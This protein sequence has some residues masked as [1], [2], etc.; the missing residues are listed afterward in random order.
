MEKANTLTA[1]KGITFATALLL[2]LAIFTSLFVETLGKAED[3]DPNKYTVTFDAN[4]GYFDEVDDKGNNKTTIARTGYK[5]QGLD[6]KSALVPHYPADDYGVEGKFFEGWTA[7]NDTKINVDEATYDPEKDITVKAVWSDKISVSFDDQQ[8]KTQGLIF[9]KQYKPKP[10]FDSLIVSL[11]A[12]SPSD[13]VSP[14][15][16]K[17]P[18]SSSST[19]NSSES[20]SV[21]I[22]VYN[23]QQISVH[24][25]DRILS[26]AGATT[27]D[28]E[29]FD[30]QGRPVFS[31]KDV[32][33]SVSLSSLS[34]GLFIVRVRNGSKSLMQRI[35]VK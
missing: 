6:D 11:K 30:M 1:R 18:E 3:K 12:H 9:D 8:G 33:A 26:I 15:P 7:T 23:L 22:P 19:E 20:Q 16:K 21:H 31:A 25:A 34:E 4:G 13:V 27:A 5:G 2:V 29:V 17:E 35:T 24:L 32:K 14:Y 28:V 10:A